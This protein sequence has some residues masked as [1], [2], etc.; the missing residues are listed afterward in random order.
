MP[1]RWE[2]NGVGL[3][4]AAYTALCSSRIT[5]YGFSLAPGRCEFVAA[6]PVPPRFCGPPPEPLSLYD[7][8][9]TSSEPEI[10]D[11]FAFIILNRHGK[12]K[13]KKIWIIANKG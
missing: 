11:V 3:A 5:K 9:P 12:Q 1:P 6:E 13:L 2:G 7:V 10:F 4:L 8:Y